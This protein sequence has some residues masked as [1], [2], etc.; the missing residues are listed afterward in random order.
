MTTSAPASVLDS[1]VI[2]STT[3]R[4]SAQFTQLRGHLICECEL[5]KKKTFEWDMHARADKQLSSTPGAGHLEVLMN[6]ILR[7]LTLAMG[8]SL[9][10]PELYKVDRR[11]RFYAR[12]GRSAR[13]PWPERYAQLIP[14]GAEDSVRSLLRWMDLPHKD[15]LAD[16]LLMYLVHLLRTGRQL[17]TPFLHTSPTFW[18]GV[19]HFIHDSRSRWQKETQNSRSGSSA[20]VARAHQEATSLI[21]TFGNFFG[22]SYA[23]VDA[24]QRKLFLKTQPDFPHVIS[25]MLLW[26]RSVQ[27]AWP[28]ADVQTAWPQFQQWAHFLYIQYA[29]LRREH[30]LFPPDIAREAE[31]LVPFMTHPVGIAFHA[32]YDLY[33]AHRCAAPGCNA[34][35]AEAGRKF[36][37]CAGCRR[38]PYCSRAC[39][40]RAWR[41]PQLAHRRVCQKLWYVA[42]EG[43]LKREIQIRV[44]MK[45]FFNTWRNLLDREP[46][47]LK[48]IIAVA[49]HLEALQQA[50]LLPPGMS[51]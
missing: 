7:S 12:S 37:H 4:S 19:I 44:D 6:T 28:H 25:S 50:K 29:P 10:G 35:Y 40:D 23:F 22:G 33:H 3:P 36:R 51:A 31:S 26:I 39:Q 46:K 41:D 18:K 34:T 45:P 11:R 32:L 27:H 30:G 47:A 43:G 38:A 13:P 42:E 1:Y 21:N 2:F 20:S 16:R 8:M 48:T 14:Y 9:G 24:E 49:G 17:V 5:T 15:V